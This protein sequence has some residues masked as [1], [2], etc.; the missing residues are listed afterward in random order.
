MQ[1]YDVVF[2]VLFA[3]V[4]FKEGDLVKKQMALYLFAFVVFVVFSQLIFGKEYSPRQGTFY[5]GMERV[6]ISLYLYA[7]V[8]YIFTSKLKTTLVFYTKPFGRIDIFDVVLAVPILSFVIYYAGVKGYRLDGSFMDYVGDRSVWVDY[9]FVYVVASLVSSRGSLIIASLAA[10]IACAHLLAGE[11]M[12][13]FVYIFSILIVVFNFS[14]RKNL[15]S[16]FLLFGFV[17]ATFI[18]LI[19]HNNVNDSYNITHF[20]SVTISS[21]MMVEESMDFGF[22]QRLKFFLGIILANIIPSSMLSADMNIR[23]FLFDNRNIPGGGWFPVWAYA[24]AGYTGVVLSALFSAIFYRFLNSFKVMSGREKTN[25]AKYTMLV[26]FI[27]T[28]P[29]WFMYTPYQILKMP[30][31]GFVLCYLLLSVKEVVLHVWVNSQK[32]TSVKKR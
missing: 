26:I 21:L 11:R 19:R 13:A 1:L 20:S 18:G 27:A 25:M 23:V 6:K 14:G 16:M 9:F 10:A 8:F 30:V 24:I 22:Y 2:C 28:L 17:V 32:N 29:R 4:F 31:Y 5:G 7:V 3:L 15:S 12:R